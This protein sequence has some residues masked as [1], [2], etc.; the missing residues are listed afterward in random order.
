MLVTRDAL[1]APLCVCVDGVTTRVE[2]ARIGL[3]LLNIGVWREVRR[4]GVL[5]WYRVRHTGFGMVLEVSLLASVFSWEQSLLR[6]KVGLVDLE[7]TGSVEGEFAEISDC[8][9]IVAVGLSVDLFLFRIG[10]VWNRGSTRC[11]EDKDHGFFEGFS[12]HGSRSLASQRWN[13]GPNRGARVLPPG[14]LIED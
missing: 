4:V 10:I 13:L 6:G 2:N 8:L 9:S 7:E 14:G 12:E 5:W 11:V 1:F 3:R